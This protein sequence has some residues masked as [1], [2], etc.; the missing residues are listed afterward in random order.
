MDRIAASELTRRCL[1]VAMAVP[2]WL[3]GERDAFP[4]KVRL[5]GF[6]CLFAPRPGHFTMS[7]E[8]RSAACPKEG[9]GHCRRVRGREG[10]VDDDDDDDEPACL[11]AC[12]CSL[13]EQCDGHQRIALPP[14]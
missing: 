5:V 12:C 14:A 13:G 3:S 1:P 10:Q 11:P 8:L 9:G 2:S 7:F 6:V 4:R